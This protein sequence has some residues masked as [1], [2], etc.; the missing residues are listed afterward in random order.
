[1]IA[2]AALLVG[3]AVL[4][5]LPAPPDRR[6]ARIAVST[7]EPTSRDPT[8]GVRFATV[9]ATSL[10]A[11]ASVL[12]VGGPL[13]ILLAVG[14]SLLL[15]RVARRLEPAEARRRRE[16]LSKQAPEVADLLAATVAS[17]ATMGSALAAVVGALGEPASGALRPVIAAMGLGADPLLAWRTISAEPVLAPIAAAVVRSAE[18]GAPLAAV[19]SRIAEDM[20]R[21][22]RV[23]VEVAAQSAGVKAVAPLA[24]C[25]LP[26]FLLMGVVPVVAALAGDVLA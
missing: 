11:L 24:A 26:A 4:L 5:G 21:E 9:A 3:S 19:L 13:G 14:I 15:P 22:R 1:M 12:V 7:R 10:G 2:I 23:A 20:R 25:F 17:G 6:L 8:G 16:A 18:T